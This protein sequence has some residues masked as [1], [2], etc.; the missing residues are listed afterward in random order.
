M[1]FAD[2]ERGREREVKEVSLDGKI[3]RANKPKR[4]RGITQI[5]SQGSDAFAPEIEKVKKLPNRF[6]LKTWIFVEEL[7][8]QNM[9]LP[10][11]SV[12]RREQINKRR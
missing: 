5:S 12:S 4:A 7:F 1:Y 8:F 9:S 10:L 11:T 2:R 3:G 6:H